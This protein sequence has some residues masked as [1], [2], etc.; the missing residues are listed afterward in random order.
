MGFSYINNVIDKKTQ[1]KKTS[2]IFSEFDLQSKHL[3]AA[4]GKI[5]IKAVNNLH[6]LKLTI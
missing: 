5:L 2:K 3:G 6:L 1:L 4:K